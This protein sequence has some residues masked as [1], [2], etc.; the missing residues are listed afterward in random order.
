[1]TKIIA[2]CGLKS[3]GK[4]TS[5][6]MLIYM[7]NTPKFMHKYS[8]YKI[9][10]AIKGRWKKTSFA[11]SLKQMLSIII[12]ESVEIFEDRTFK[13]YYYINL[14]TFEKRW[15]GELAPCQVLSDNQFSKLL[16]NEQ[17]DTITSSFIS[18]RQLMQYVG[19]NVCRKYISNDVW[20]NSTLQDTKNIVIADLRFQREYEIINKHNGILIYIN[21]P[22]CEPGN[23]ASEREVYELYTKGAFKHELQNNGTLKDLFYKIKHEIRNSIL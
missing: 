11:K 6:D 18:I 12:N 10:G 17:Y 4:D 21:R 2:M 14:S 8:W 15:Y 16:K 1:M 22:G 13:E 20:I 23:H 3:A 9:F 5:A 7:L 19:T